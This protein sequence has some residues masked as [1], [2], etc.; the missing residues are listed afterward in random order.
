MR[1]RW[2]ERLILS[3]YLD[4]FS[5]FAGMYRMEYC[6]RLT[7]MVIV[8]YTGRKRTMKERTGI[9]PSLRVERT[10]RLSVHVP[11]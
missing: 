2:R 9:R 8:S 6:V 1:Q 4:D 7:Y 3:A 5:S 11:Q 10:K